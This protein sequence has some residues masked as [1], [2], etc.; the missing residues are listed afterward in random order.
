MNDTGPTSS[1]QPESTTADSYVA[2][3]Y[4]VPAATDRIS[5]ATPAAN[6]QKQR[7]TGGRW[8]AI[9]VALVVAVV[10]VIFVLQNSSDTAVAFLGW[11]GS[12]PLSL[13]LLIAAFSGILVTAAVSTWRSAHRRHKAK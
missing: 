13:A 2:A 5:A 8:F 7:G 4:E 10:F 12:I 11:R 9:I 1:R 6:Q 3:P